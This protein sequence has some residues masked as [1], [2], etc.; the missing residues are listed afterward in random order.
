MKLKRILL[1]ATAAALI[2]LEVA[3]SIAA[4][5]QQAILG[6]FTGDM[7]TSAGSYATTVS[8]F[9]GGTSFGSMAGQASSGVNITGG[10]ITGIAE[11]FRQLTTGATT[12]LAATDKFVCINKT[13]GSATAVAGLATPVIGQPFYVKDCKGDAA[14]NNV[15]FTPGSG[16]TIDGAAS[17]VINQNFGGVGLVYTSATTVAAF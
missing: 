13:T 11:G 1:G 14:T 9:N 6:A 10:T 12:T 8:K 2:A 16:V 5:N 7:T 4:I 17:Y 3:P 15:T